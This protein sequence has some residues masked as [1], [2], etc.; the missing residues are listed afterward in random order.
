MASSAAEGSVIEAARL[1]KAK[2]SDL[3]LTKK[4]GLQYA[5]TAEFSD[6]YSSAPTF[7]YES[8]TKPARSLLLVAVKLKE[9]KI[10][11]TT[12][13]YVRKE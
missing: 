6:D 10:L 13:T 5:E 2:R 7:V 1:A 8:V 9:E 4:T 3:D 12:W 11:H